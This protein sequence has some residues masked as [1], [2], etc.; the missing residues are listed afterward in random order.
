MAINE[1]NK[2]GMMSAYAG[3]TPYNSTEAQINKHI[4]DLNTTF[5]GKVTNCTSN[6]ATDSGTSSNLYSIE[7]GMNA[8]TTVKINNSVVWENGAKK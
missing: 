8:G 5:V 2:R 1:N 7:S 3:T 4:Q 6:A